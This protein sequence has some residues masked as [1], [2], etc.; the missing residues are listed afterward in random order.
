MK[1]LSKSKL[2]Y[3]SR[4]GLGA[5]IVAA[6]L[7]TAATGAVQAAI[8]PL[9]AVLR[10]QSDLQ[11]SDVPVQYAISLP[12]PTLRCLVPGFASFA[13]PALR[14]PDQLLEQGVP[15]R[16]WV[17]DAKNGQLLLYALTRQLPFGDETSWKAVTEPAPAGTVADL[18]KAREQIEQQLDELA[19]AFFDHQPVPEDKRH[20]FL[21][22]LRAYIG[23]ELIPQYEALAPDF[24]AWLQSNDAPDGTPSK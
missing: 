15:D 21:R 9:S 7:H 23:P 6:M 20:S 16:W 19:P 17:V 4:S 14:R 3:M 8:I 2:C 18:Q 1:S 10:K 11:R 24:F 13:S 12:L 22:A 5:I